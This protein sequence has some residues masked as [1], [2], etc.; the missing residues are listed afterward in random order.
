MISPEKRITSFINRHHVLTLA[1]CNNNRTWCSSCFY[2]YDSHNASIIFTSDIDTQHAIE[3][4]KNPIVAGNIVLETKAIG[5]IQ[6]AQLTGTLQKTEGDLHKK[7]KLLYLKKFPFAILANT[8]M[9]VLEIE[10]I[11]LTDNRLGFGKK[12]YWNRKN[13]NKDT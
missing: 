6:G 11:K 8:D 3:A 12:L 10:T 13:E 4:I 1:T 2:V 5:K 7:S 9:W